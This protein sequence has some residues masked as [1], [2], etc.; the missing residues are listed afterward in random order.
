MLGS[1]TSGS[2]DCRARF[3]ITLVLTKSE[4]YNRLPLDINT[5]EPKSTP[6]VKRVVTALVSNRIV[7][8]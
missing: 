4:Y 2:P 7:W 6:Y 3:F 1:E 5:N 8:E